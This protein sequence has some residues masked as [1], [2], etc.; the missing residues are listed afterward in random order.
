MQYDFIDFKK[1]CQFV[2]KNHILRMTVKFKFLKKLYKNKFV[3]KI[4]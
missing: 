4:L 1:G 3:V 2:L